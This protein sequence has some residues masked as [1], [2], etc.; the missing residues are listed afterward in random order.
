MT[1]TRH[2]QLWHRHRV[3]DL[4][5]CSLAHLTYEEFL[6]YTEAHCRPAIETKP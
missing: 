1:T 6:E 2:C 4:I 5:A 3:D